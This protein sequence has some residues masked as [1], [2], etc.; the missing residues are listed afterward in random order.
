VIQKCNSRAT[1]SYLR[2]AV[3]ARAVKPT[4]TVPVFQ[5]VP[6]AIPTLEK[7]KRHLPGCDTTSCKNCWRATRQQADTADRNNITDAWT[8]HVATCMR[9][10]DVGKTFFTALLAA[11][12]ASFI[13][14]TE[15]GSHEYL[16]VAPRLGTATGNACGSDSPGFRSSCVCVVG[17]SCICGVVSSASCVCVVGRSCICGVGSIATRLAGSRR[18]GDTELSAFFLRQ[19]LAQRWSFFALLP[20]LVMCQNRHCCRWRSSKHR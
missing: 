1:D 5:Q 14:V 19:D 3:S 8:A 13:M 18:C 20:Q 4:T 11:R 7:S 16:P 10:L 17:R 12:A 9:V 15:P 2:R 6:G